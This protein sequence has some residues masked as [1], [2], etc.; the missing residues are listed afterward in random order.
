VTTSGPHGVD[1][2]DEALHQPDSPPLGNESY[3]LDAVAADGS[4]GLYARLGR[5][6]NLG[7]TWWTA[8]VVG[9]DRPM[10]AS[11]AYDLPIEGAPG[12]SSGSVVSVETTPMD[13]SDATDGRDT[14]SPT[15]FSIECAT[16]DPLSSMTVTATVPASRHR[17]AT[18]IY[19]GAVGTPTDLS[20]EAEWT[21]DGIPYHYDI[22][23][24]YEI[25]CLV[26]GQ[27][28]VGN[29]RFALDGPGQRDHSWGVRDWWAFGWCWA[30]FRLD[31]GTRLHFADIRIP[32]SP[33]TFGYVQAPGENVA[34]IER[35]A[36]R[37]SSG[38][39]GLPVAGW[40]SIEPGGLDLT[41][42]PVAF[43]PVVLTATDGRVSRFPRAM[44]RCATGD[45]RRG[46]GWIEWNQPV[47]P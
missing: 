8:M 35:L 26:H 43:G 19:D 12:E 37:E 14:G 45:G 34:S 36:V 16:P 23:T 20:I 3:S 40:A 18:E 47:A 21:T 46:L 24:R 1:R 6:P 32:S 22:T 7:V 11:V 13:P 33:M 31:D 27:I 44:A 25:P 10:V 42:D 28:A 15:G 4:V 2:R 29:E 41:I 38:A 39:D 9:P 30:A 5:Y 17:V